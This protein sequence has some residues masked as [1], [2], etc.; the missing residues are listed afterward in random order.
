[1]AETFDTHSA[2]QQLREGER[3][4]DKQ[5]KVLVELVNAAIHSKPATKDDLRVLAADLKS[6][7][8]AATAKLWAEYKL[9]KVEVKIDFNALETRIEND[10]DALRR[11]IKNDFEV[12]K[13]EVKAEVS[14]TLDRTGKFP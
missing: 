14:K 6:E 13:V 3:F 8:R 5:A 7:I 9:H 11:E 4:N 1:M 12:L 2:Y 10:V